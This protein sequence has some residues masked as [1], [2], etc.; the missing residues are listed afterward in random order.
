M[1]CDTGD[2]AVGSGW[3]RA[4][5]CGKTRVGLIWDIDFS[6]LGSV[7]CCQ[8][9]DRAVISA[10]LTIV[11]VVE[12]GMSPDSKGSCDDTAPHRSL[13]QA[14]DGRMFADNC[15]GETDVSTRRREEAARGE[16]TSWRGVLVSDIKNRRRLESPR[17]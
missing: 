3:P 12:D 2:L 1:S 14:E 9:R 15:V 8:C 10:D 17:R 7:V 16:E 11:V 5:P 6:S 13:C 4:A